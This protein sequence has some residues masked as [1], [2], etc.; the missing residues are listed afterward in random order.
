[1]YTYWYDAYIN[2]DLNKNKSPRLENMRLTWFQEI[3]LQKAF[4]T[5]L[6]RRRKLTEIGG[7]YLKDLAPETL[8]K[9]AR[10]V[11]DH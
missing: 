11:E 7:L 8:V 5:A 2:T 6:G 4:K 3:A 10:D 9:T 1:M